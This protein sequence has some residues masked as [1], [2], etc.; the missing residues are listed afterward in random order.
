MADELQHRLEKVHLLEEKYQLIIKGIDRD[1][2]LKACFKQ[3]QRKGNNIEK[4]AAK[5]PQA[6]S[7]ALQDALQAYERL[8]GKFQENIVKHIQ[9]GVKEI[10]KQYYDLKNRIRNEQFLELLEHCNLAGEW[11][12]E[13]KGND[14][15]TF[16]AL[17]NRRNNTN[18][19]ALS[20]SV[21]LKLNLELGNGVP[22]EW[23]FSA[24]CQAFT[25]IVYEEMVR[26]VHESLP[27]IHTPCQTALRRR[28]L[29]P[30]STVGFTYRVRLVDKVDLE[31]K[32]DPSEAGAP[33]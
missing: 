4:E 17:W 24:V 31:S 14:W 26:S 19:R 29:Y 16:L 7:K 21:R 13:E 32:V 8:E 25:V 1:P 20:K 2:G 30:C 9:E 12:E 23:I 28:Q 6:T 27:K 33:A 18:M 5:D 11:F 10:G 22:A 3:L 15:E